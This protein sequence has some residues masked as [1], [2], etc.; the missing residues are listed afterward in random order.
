[1]GLRIRGLVKTMNL[2][3][4]RLADGLDHDEV[5]Q[6]RLTVLRALRSVEAACRYYRTRP[7]AL[8]TPSLRAYL[9]L[10]DLDLH[11]LPIRD[12]D[13]PPP[14]PKPPQVR[15]KNLIN[16]CDRIHHRMELLVTGK[17]TAAELSPNQVTAL[18]STIKDHVSRV[19]VLCQEQGGTPMQMPQRSR[20]AYRWLHLLQKQELLEAHL[21]ALAQAVAAATSFIQQQGRGMTAS[22]R[23]FNISHLYRSAPR[24]GCLQVTI[25]EAF[26]GAPVEVIHAIVHATLGDRKPAHLQRLRAYADTKSFARLALAL[27]DDDHERS[28]RGNHHDLAESFERVNQT[29]FD[30]RLSPP[31]LTWSKTLT[32][33]KLGHYRP[34]TDTVMISKSV[35]TPAAPDYVVDFLMYHELLHRVLGIKEVNGRR[36]IHTPRFRA[37]EKRFKQYEQAEAALQKLIEASS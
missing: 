11:S 26:I 30:G 34:S 20:R 9:F 5:D 35:D 7:E 19:E 27:S 22:V 33:R 2:V 28:A 25:N 16:A 21:V 32:M 1:M 24:H 37:E 17:Q 31:R 29:Y 15:I 23:F 3:R 8:P 4:Q 14:V 6:L 13:Q 12:P 10:K 36:R 18:R